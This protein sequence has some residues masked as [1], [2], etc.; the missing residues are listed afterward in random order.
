VGG[1]GFIGSQV[2]LMLCRAGYKTLVFDNLSRGSRSAVIQGSFVEGDISNPKDLDKVF[3]SHKIDAVMHFAAYIDVG[4]SCQHPLKYYQN[5]VGGTLNLLEAM[6]RHDVKI[7]VFSSSAA[8]YGY[9]L[10]L[11]IDEQHPCNPI[12]PYGETKWMVEKIL[13]DCDKAYG[14]RSCCLRYFNAAG[15]DPEGM[16]TNTRTKEHN[17][18][19]L[20]LRSL[21]KKSGS[22]TIFGTDYDT[23]DG[24]C[25]RDYVHVHDLGQA[26]IDAM[27]KLLAGG[28]SMCY[29][30]GNGHGF[31]IRQVIAAAEEATGLKV[32]T[33][34]GGRRPGDPPILVADA[35]KAH[36]ELGWTPQYPDLE[37]MIAHAWKAMRD[38]R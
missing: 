8:V 23:S 10:K 2:N 20:I 11:K 9:P 12:N 38:E 35:H 6:V 13:H 33:V 31:T 17:L 37:T 24:T 3:S 1:A 32:R 34:E 18:I 36:D 27:K 15:G 30:L 26:H 28:P 4:E 25:I 19:P 14:L 5:N 7:L 22:I 21:Q 29:N 16:I